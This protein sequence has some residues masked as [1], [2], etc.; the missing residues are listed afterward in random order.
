MPLLALWAFMAYSREKFTF[1]F[2]LLYNK[3]T[4]GEA[5]I[6]SHERNFSIEV[7]IS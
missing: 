7:F 6:P 2:T 3:M 4:R 5:C 1:T